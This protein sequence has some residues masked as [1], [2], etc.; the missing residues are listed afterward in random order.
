MKTQYK[1]SEHHIWIFGLNPEYQSYKSYPHLF[2]RCPEKYWIGIGKKS[3][4]GTDYDTVMK[5]DNYD[6]A[7]KHFEEAA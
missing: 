2:F 5:T 7:K 1:S 6:L 4:H 3:I